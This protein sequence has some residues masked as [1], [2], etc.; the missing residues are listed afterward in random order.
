MAS[1][2][3]STHVQLGLVGDSEEVRNEKAEQVFRR[4]SELLELELANKSQN[5]RSSRDRAIRALQEQQLRQK[6]RECS[7]IKRQDVQNFVQNNPGQ[8]VKLVCISTEE[9]GRNVMGIS[10]QKFERLPPQ[11]SYIQLHRNELAQDE[12]KIMY[13]VDNDGEVIP[14]DS[15]GQLVQD[16]RWIGSDL[17]RRLKVVRQVLQESGFCSEVQKGLQRSLDCSASNLRKMITAVVNSSEKQLLGNQ[18]QKGVLSQQMTSLEISDALNVRYKTICRRCLNDFCPYHG[19]EHQTCV[20]QNLLC[21]IIQ[22]QEACGRD[23]GCG[24]RQI[25]EHVA[26]G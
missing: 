1:F 15:E 2:G 9:S 6:F 24:C 26:L 22:A 3:Q 20:P 4:A 19:G 8:D 12:G 23:C 25:I 16:F 17:T 21:K 18:Q 14:V 5:K 7:Q 11:A 13:R 10:I